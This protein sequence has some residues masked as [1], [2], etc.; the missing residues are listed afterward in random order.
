MSAPALIDPQG[1]PL[2]ASYLR[3]PGEQ[4]YPTAYRAADLRSQETYAWRPPFTSGES[5]T[6][7]ERTLAAAR[8]RD[9]VRND[10]HGLS[11]TNVIV[12]MLIGAG[13]QWAPMPNAYALGLDASKAADRKKLRSLARALKGEWQ[14]FA[15]DPRKL[16]DAQRRLSFNGQLRLLARTW[17]VLNEATGFL[18][19]KDGRARYKTCLR[20]IDPDRLSNPMGQADT[21][22]LRGGIDYDSDGVP[23]AYHVRNGHPSD[24]FRYAQLLQWT[25]IPA[26]TKWGRPVF[27]HV[28]EGDREDQSR[29]ISHMAAS[30]I[31]HRMIGKAADAEIANMVVNALF[32]AFV[33]SNL[34]IAEATQAFT[35]AGMTW[36]DK[37][38]EYLGKNP[39]HLNGVRIPVLPPGDEVKINAA[40][41]NT[42]AF[43]GMQTAFLQSIAAARGVSYEQISMDWSKVNYSSARA[44]L[45]EVWRSVQRKLAQ[46]VDQAVMPIA[47][48][49]IEEAFDRGYIK[50]PKGAPDFWDMP[51]AYLTG[52]WIGPARGYVDP[53][54][55]AQA[56]GV[57]M[58]NLTSTLEQECAEAG[59]DW[60]DVLLQASEEEDVI[61]QFGLTRQLSAIGRIEPDASD[62]TASGRDAKPAQEAV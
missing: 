9:I 33:S 10:P 11:G 38:A 43:A 45:N 41:R 49:V 21:L 28:F 14:I 34:P 20:I 59:R 58:G 13:L 32:A 2:R 24:W 1:N 27:I 19:W 42:A 30:L 51:G 55:E 25:R 39:V 54:K 17:A 5:E 26:R 29:A 3:E 61:K 16:S 40:T 12:D 60:E 50:P 8:A 18:T 15:N 53:E 47:Y 56:A 52:R 6:L 35:P 62:L 7:Y 23:L 48:A 36:M 57:R 37:R 44:A 4:T 31:K 46:F 22:T